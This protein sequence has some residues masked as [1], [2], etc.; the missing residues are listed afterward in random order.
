MENLMTR[1]LLSLAV[2]GA[3]SVS[4]LLAAGCESNPPA[5]Q[6]YSLTGESQEN[7][8]VTTDNTASRPHGQP[9][10]GGNKAFYH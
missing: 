1:K 5:T 2:L 7:R 6:P 10:W 3:V 9:F 8:T 4:T